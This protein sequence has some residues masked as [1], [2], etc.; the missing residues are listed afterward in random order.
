[1]NIK[2]LGATF[3]AVGLAGQSL[4]ISFGPTV[5]VDGNSYTLGGGAGVNG[6]AVQQIG[7]TIAFALPNGFSVGSNKTMTLEYSVAATP[8]YTLSSINQIA[9]NGIA[10]G[11][12]SVNI[13]TSFTGAANETA[14]SIAYPSGSAFNPVSYSFTTS[15]TQWNTV[16][17]VIDLNGAGGIAKVSTYN[18]NYT[19][20][21]PEPVS[22]AVLAS[23]LG[24]LVLQRRRGKK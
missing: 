7:N 4:A 18:A 17:T 14:P 1:M 3:L 10:T 16:K 12:A 2:G 22:V 15:P 24:A 8:G 13:S 19:E 21:V 9:G 23:G 20:V 6:I 11:T 5:T